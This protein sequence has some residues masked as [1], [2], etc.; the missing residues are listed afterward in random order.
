MNKPFV[1]SFINLMG[2]NISMKLGDNQ[3]VSIGQRMEVSPWLLVISAWWIY[4]EIEDRN[5]I[6]ICFHDPDDTRDHSCRC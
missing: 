3:I 2:E 5:C 6:V 4:F 1:T